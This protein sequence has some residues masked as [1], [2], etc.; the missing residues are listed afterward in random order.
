VPVRRLLNDHAP[1]VLA[2]GGGGAPSSEAPNAFRQQFRGL[3]RS[4]ER[5]CHT[6]LLVLTRI[7]RRRWN[8]RFD[9]CAKFVRARLSRINQRFPN[10]LEKY[11]SIPQTF[12]RQFRL[13][14]FSSCPSFSTLGGIL[15]IS[16]GFP[17]DFSSS[18]AALSWSSISCCAAMNSS[19]TIRCRWR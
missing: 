18:C 14:G 5:P 19:C 10:L 11:Q 1:I 6:S 2:K 15:R 13:S 9:W 7:I 16:F 3:P 8:G 12:N 17:A 4:E